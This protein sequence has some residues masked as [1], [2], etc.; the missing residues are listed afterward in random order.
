MNTKPVDWV[1]WV[2]LITIF[3]FTTIKTESKIKQVTK[4]N[5]Q[6]VLPKTLPV[7]ETVIP[8]KLTET[9]VEI[10]PEMRVVPIGVTGEICTPETCPPP[11]TYSNQ[12]IFSRWRRR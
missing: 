9:I 5:E 4:Q 6:I 1:I 3:V 11:V 10:Q 7:V 2:S 8:D 12:K